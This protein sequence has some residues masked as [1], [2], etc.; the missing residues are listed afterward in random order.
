VGEIREVMYH[1]MNEQVAVDAFTALE[2]GQI[3][4]DQLAPMVYT[5]AWLRGNLLW[6]TGD[7][8]QWAP[9][10]TG[11][12]NAYVYIYSNTTNCSNCLQYY[13]SVRHRGAEISHQ[14]YV[15]TNGISYS[16]TGP[17]SWSC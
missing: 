16:W 13:V 4:A 10:I 5:A 2:A 12:E 11:K 17:N 8:A 6:S 1:S 14:R 15:T 7:V 9:G 3:N